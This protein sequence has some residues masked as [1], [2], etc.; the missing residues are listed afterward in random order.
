[1]NNE[2]KI[3]VVINTYNAQQHLERVL[4]AVSGFDEILVCDMES[5]DS[6]LDIARRRGCRIV[7]FPKKDYTIVEPAR[8]FAI[9]Q[10][11]YEWVLVVDAD[12]LVTP[13]LRDYLYQR[14]SKPNCP[15]GLYI[16]RHNRFMGQYTRAFTADHQL[17][18][19]RQSLTHWPAIIH[20]APQVDGLTEKIPKGG[21]VKFVHLANETIGELLEKCDR[22]TDNDLLKKQHKNYGAAALLLR[23][24]W[25][26][27][28][29]YFLQGNYRD[30]LRGLLFSGMKAVYQFAL[31]AKVIEKKLR[32]EE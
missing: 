15:D 21:N 13:Q 6:T 32:V 24:L 3:S 4:D 18:F 16:P 20:A 28:S 5:T 7:T 8:E 17:R 9:H 22:Y 12:E 2:C 25:K 27:F 10:A 19:F 14:I 26:F 31:V 11:Q 23:P 29:F 1:M 30:G